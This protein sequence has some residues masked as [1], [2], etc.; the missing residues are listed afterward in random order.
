MPD[1]GRF[2]LLRFF[3]LLA[4]GYMEQCIL[5]CIG[6]IGV[7]GTVC[8]ELHCVECIGWHSLVCIELCNLKCAGIHSVVWASCCKLYWVAFCSVH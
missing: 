7:H 1:V 6:D 8:I 5:G 3:I 4:L 2:C